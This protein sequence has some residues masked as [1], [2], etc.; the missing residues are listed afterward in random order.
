[1]EQRTLQYWETGW[2]FWA[3]YATSVLAL[4]VIPRERISKVT[5]VHSGLFSMQGL[6]PPGSPVSENPGKIY[7]LDL[8][9]PKPTPVELQI[10]GNLDLDSFNPH[11]ISVYTDNAG[12][13]QIMMIFLFSIV[14]FHLNKHNFILELISFYSKILKQHVLRKIDCII[15][16]HYTGLNHKAN[17]IALLMISLGFKDLHVCKE[18]KAKQYC[19]E[20][21][22]RK[23]NNHK[24]VFQ[25]WFSYTN[26]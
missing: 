8:L 10:K 18:R 7:I 15:F 14:I 2:L 16:V 1:M 9:H 3:R 6:K 17:A 4:Y 21:I 13:I 22:K 11:G 26:K 12:D 24:C 20:E 23:K 5:R 19:T 25:K